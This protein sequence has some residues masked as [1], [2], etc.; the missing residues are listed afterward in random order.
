METLLG[1]GLVPDFLIRLGVRK[2]SMQ[3]LKEEYSKDH[4]IEWFV[5]QLSHGDIAEKTEAANEQ[6]YEVPSEFFQY[7]L[8]PNLKYSCC[9]FDDMTMSLEQAENAMLELYTK[10]AELQDGMTILDL[11]CGWGSLS[12]F[13]AKK[14]PNSKI[15]GVS[16]S[17]TQKL[18]IDQVA[19]ERGIKNLEIRTCDINELELEE[20]FDRI[21]S[22]E[23]FEHMRNYKQLLKKVASWLK[24][25]GKVF[26]HIFTHK[27]LPYFY[28]V[29]DSTDFMTKYFFEGGIMPS[30]DML[31]H[32]DEHL[33]MVNSWKV[34]GKHYAETSE[35]WLQNMD[36]NRREVLACFKNAYGNRYKA[37]FEY[38]R[39]FFIACAE[40]F[41]MN[42]GNEWFVTHYLLEKKS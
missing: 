29:R 38:W 24:D 23:M 27:D 6:H 20:R 37:W 40:F 3:R 30:T 25:E 28:E 26:I 31:R 8:G 14:Y 21:M 36:N 1:T 19:K 39:V 12:L 13:L 15:I 16:N 32:F 22:I 35:R 2:L 41:K 42:D 9:L 4:G 7:A 11:G 5:E 10:R 33:Q 18:H 34:N 17:S